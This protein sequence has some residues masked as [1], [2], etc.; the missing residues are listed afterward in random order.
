[1]VN[2]FRLRPYTELYLMAI[3]FYSFRTCV[4]NKPFP[5]SWEKDRLTQI[6]FAT[7]NKKAVTKRYTPY[8]Q[9][10]RTL[11]APYI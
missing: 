9:R 7:D 2:V 3:A 6:K 11:N 10:V 5:T 1:M 4:E 8:N